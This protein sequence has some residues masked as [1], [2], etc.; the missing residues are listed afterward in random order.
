MNITAYNKAIVALIMAIIGI[1]NLKW[2][3][4]IGLDQDTVTAV[5]AAL[6]P[7]LVWIVPNKPSAP[8][9]APAPQPSPDKA[10]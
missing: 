4:L 8:A 7:I 5:V 3:G 2:P 10:Q 9:A 6:T 1:V